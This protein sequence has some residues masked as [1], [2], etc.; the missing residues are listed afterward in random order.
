[1]ECLG[2]ETSQANINQ[3]WREKFWKTNSWINFTVP[4]MQLDSKCPRCPKEQWRWNSPRC[5]L[6]GQGSSHRSPLSKKTSAE[7]AQHGHDRS[8]QSSAITIREVRT[9]ALSIKYCSQYISIFTFSLATFTAKLGVF[10]S[11]TPTQK[12]SIYLIMHA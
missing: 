9:K 5:I 7:V 8:T 11:P 2:W 6:C 3:V 12:Y 1:M 4:F 10:N